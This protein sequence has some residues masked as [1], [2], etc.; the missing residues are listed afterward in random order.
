MA[1][2]RVL[3]V[4]MPIVVSTLDDRDHDVIIGIDPY[5]WCVTWRSG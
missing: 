1:R 4:G 5:G 2:T 3:E